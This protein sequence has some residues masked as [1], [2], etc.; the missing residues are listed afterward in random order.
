MPPGPAPPPLAVVDRGGRVANLVAEEGTVTFTAEVSAETDVRDVVDAVTDRF[1]ETRL[2]AKREGERSVETEAEFRQRLNDRL[3]DR[4]RTVLRAAYHGG[5]YEW[6]RGSTA[7]ELADALDVA[8]PTLH[9]HLRKA[10]RTLLAAFFD[11]RSE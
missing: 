6:P 3:T 8:S 5:Y 1:P 9:D 4:Q 7:E 2:A 10:Q 11:D